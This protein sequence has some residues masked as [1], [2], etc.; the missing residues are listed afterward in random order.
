MTQSDA[1]C[2]LGC[3]AVYAMRRFMEV[4]LVGAAVYK[5]PPE[6]MSS[7]DQNAKG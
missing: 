5:L 1:N 7:G 2:S 3:G 6:F 4:S